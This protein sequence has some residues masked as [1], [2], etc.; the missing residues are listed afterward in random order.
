M[1]SIE[2]ILK[3]IKFNAKFYILFFL[4]GIVLFIFI[5]ST[6]KGTFTSKLT[7]NIFSNKSL[8]DSYYNLKDSFIF[9]F[10]QE[11]FAILQ[12]SDTIANKS[13]DLYIENNF[14]T[15]LEKN[16]NLSTITTLRSGLSNSNDGYHELSELFDNASQKLYLKFLNIIENKQKNKIAKL[17]NYINSLENQ[18]TSQEKEFNNFVQGMIISLEQAK[19]I[20]EL[21]SANNFLNSEKNDLVV[22]TPLSVLIQKFSKPD[23]ESEYVNDNYSMITYAEGYDII[24]KKLEQAKSI[25]LNTLKII[26]P[27][28]NSNK[29]KISSTKKEIISLNK[30]YDNIY[31]NLPKYLI[32]QSFVSISTEKIYKFNRIITGIGILLVAIVISTFLGF[33]NVGI[34]LEE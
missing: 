16:E 34:K 23:K 15:S 6:D 33:L 7:I 28:Y 32:P 4:T 19:E 30:S 22:N 3:F 12:S 25:D 31:E 14:S 8:T 20:S 13:D 29:T 18:I 27:I 24:S 1:L 2:T 9:N 17:Q 21:S 5:T 11:L 26:S 10:E